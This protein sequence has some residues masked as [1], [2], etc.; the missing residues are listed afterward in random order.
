MWKRWFTKIQPRL[1]RGSCWPEAATPTASER[2]FL[3]SGFTHTTWNI[4]IVARAYKE[5][6]RTIVEEN[7][8]TFWKKAQIRR[9]IVIATF[10]SWPLY[11]FGM[12]AAYQ[13]IFLAEPRFVALLIILIS[14]VMLLTK[15]VNW[16]NRLKCPSCG[17]TPFN[18][19]S[20]W[21]R[22]LR[23]QYCGLVE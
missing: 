7:L 17:L 2:R 22:K 3:W 16:V 1:V 19:N 12:S 21:K 11:G 9:R 14:W 20:F 6:S 18:R 10:F 5:D 8:I 15:V 13:V 4:C 23:C